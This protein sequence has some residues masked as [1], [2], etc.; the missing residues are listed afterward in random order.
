MKLRTASCWHRGVSS[1]LALGFCAA[2]V[3][4]RPALDSARYAAT[5]SMFAHYPARIGHTIRPSPGLPHA[6]PCRSAVAAQSGAGR[7]CL[8]HATETGQSAAHGS[9]RA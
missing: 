7:S 9:Q 8:A 2:S 4:E 3:S 1:G 5:C 6:G